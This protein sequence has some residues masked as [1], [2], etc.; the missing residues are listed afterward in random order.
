MS[1]WIIE[2]SKTHLFDF[3]KP[4]YF[5]F[6]AMKQYYH[7]CHKMSVHL[8]NSGWVREMITMN[9]WIFLSEILCASPDTTTLKS[10]QQINFYGCNSLS[11][12][13]LQYIEIDRI[14]GTLPNLNAKKIHLIIN[15]PIS[16]MPYYIWDPVNWLQV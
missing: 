16:Y 15:N 3:C 2:D 10:S 9:V 6:R 1:W 4:Q 14:L 7:H 11:K 8:W 5:I 12:Q 13:K